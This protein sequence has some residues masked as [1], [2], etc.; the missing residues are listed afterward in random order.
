MSNG[1]GLPQYSKCTGLHRQPTHT[2]RYAR[3]A[4]GGPEQG[5][6]PSSGW[7][8]G[9]PGCHHHQMEEQLGQQRDAV[10]QEAD[11]SSRLT[12]GH[13]EGCRPEQSKH[14]HFGR[15]I[16]SGNQHPEGSHFQNYSAMEAVNEDD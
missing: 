4:L 7:K 10:L 5:R 16:P 3:E 11:V 6:G 1:K 14:H 9:L 13:T 15:H 12:R 2:H 8:W